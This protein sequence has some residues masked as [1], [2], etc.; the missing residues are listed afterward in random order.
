VRIER[1]DGT[2]VDAPR[3]VGADGTWITSLDRST[4]GVHVIEV[5]D[6]HGRVWCSGRFVR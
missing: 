6:E 4:T 1:R 3:P 2:W 5:V